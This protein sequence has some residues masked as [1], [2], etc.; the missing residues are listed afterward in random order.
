MR[1][2][3]AKQI[4]ILKIMGWKQVLTCA[5]C[6]LLFLGMLL[7][8]LRE[9]MQLGNEN[10]YRNCRNCYLL[11]YS[12]VGDYLRLADDAVESAARRIEEMRD[13]NATSEQI[14]AYMVKE[15]GKLDKRIADP[16]TGIYGYIDGVFLD[17][18]GWTPP[19][20]YKPTQRPWYLGAMS[21]R[22]GVAHVT[23]FSNLQTGSSTI[24][25]C[26]TIGNGGSVVAID[27]PIENLQRLVHELVEGDGYASVGDS[28]SYALAQLFIMDGNGVIIAHSDD[29]ELL[30]NYAQS[31]DPALR[32]LTQRIVIKGDTFFRM[33]HDG[34]SNVYCGGRLDK[35][36]FVYSVLDYGEVTSRITRNLAFSIAAAIVGIAGLVAVMVSLALRRYH[37]AIIRDYATEVEEENQKLEEKAAAALKIAELTKSVTALLENMPGMMFSKDVET[38]EYLAC[39]QAFA[40]F[41]MRGSADEII[42]LT[43]SDLFGEENAAKYAEKDKQALSMDRPYSYY[44]ESKNAAGRSYQLQTTKLKFTDA[45]GRRCLLGVCQDFTE[46]VRVRQETEEARAAYERAKSAGDLYESIAKA[47]SANY[48]ALYYVEVETGNYV[49]YQEEAL[50]EESGTDFF[51]SS[52]KRFEPTIVEEDRETFD[53]ELSKENVLQAVRERGEMNLNYRIR[54]RDETVYCKLHVSPL[55]GDERHL[56]FEFSVDNGIDARSDM[57]GLRTESAFYILGKELLQKHPEGWC[58]IAVDLEHFKLFNEWYGRE[59]GDKLLAQIGELFSTVETKIGGLAG[60]LGQDDF[61]LIAPYEEDKVK[62]LF[63]H[64]HE[65]VIEYGTSV[66]FMPAFGVCMADG[67]AS[68]EE[69]LDRAS[70]AAQHAKEDYHRRIRV[71]EET[72]YKKTEQDYQIL[73]DFQLALQ[74]HELFIQLQPQCEIAGGKVVGAES[75]VRWKKADGKMVSPGIF[76]PVLE[77]YGF[78]TDLDQFVWEEVCAWQKAWI[79]GGHTPL[80][81]SVNVSQIDI[82]TIDVPSYFDLLMWKY[83]LPV[84]VIKIEITESAYVG[85]GAV[86]DTVR[87]LREKGFLVLMDDFGS[88]YS[89]LNMLRSLNVDIIKLDAKFLRMNSD[90]RKGVQILES[91][92]GMAKSMEAPIIVEGVETE[93][94][95]EFIKNLGCRYVQGYHFYRPMPVPDFEKLIGDEGNIDTG[96]F[97]L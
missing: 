4:G 90:D 24:T 58:V 16:S 79:D 27:L 74:N 57:T 43:D 39:N 26:K 37:E 83:K 46:L 60:Y 15:S 71:F 67:R 85:D 50:G 69:L 78:V 97:V 9:L 41:A 20:D 91:I 72:M 64:V 82:F 22:G 87:R 45:S 88:G 19:E 2:A 33:D 84:D 76:V 18:T 47:L 94:E 44:E 77:Q 96:G 36:W 81:I 7:L 49:S 75:L 34:K 31:D 25:V 51:D 11:A 63:N 29:A 35:D 28:A 73:S 17:A 23:P 80:P 95:T 1:K 61:A 55:Q 40:E 3:K 54:K 8:N 68:V 89:S 66:G 30:K 56:I 93:E 6:C 42:G 12:E 10:A 59:T 14:L 13:S 62:Q 65:F 21:A 92:V 70:Q 38:G 52:K 32:D 48:F 5:L 86:A 53:R